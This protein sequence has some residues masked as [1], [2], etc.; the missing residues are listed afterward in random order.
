M[1][2]KLSGP[3]WLIASIALAPQPALYGQA[4]HLSPAKGSPGETVAIE[5][6]LEAPAGKEPSALQWEIVIPAGQLSFLD[7]VASAGRAA[8]TAGKAVSCGVKT[9]TAPVHTALCILYGGLGAI[10]NG[11][12]A[13]LRLKVNSD[14]PPGASRITIDHGLAVSKDLK[15]V[16]IGAGE[17]VVKIGSGSLAGVVFGTPLAPAYGSDPRP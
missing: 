14:A 4:L 12:V 15:Q 2:P 13:V 8:H 9:Q 11:V 1:H 6:S 7:E 17:T 10:P 5:I 16:A 3:F